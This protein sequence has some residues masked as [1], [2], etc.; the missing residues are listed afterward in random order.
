M[1]FYSSFLCEVFYFWA[2]APTTGIS[3]CLSRVEINRNH[4]TL[5][6][7]KNRVQYAGETVCPDCICGYT[8]GFDSTT[9]ATIK[10]AVMWFYFS[11]LWEG[12]LFL[13]YQ[14]IR[15]GSFS[16]ENL[17]GNAN[18]GCADEQIF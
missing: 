1:R 3:A 8:R 4:A 16:L 17:V 11:F 10:E 7:N 6:C 14:C 18:T 2:K 5:V 9:F 12:F 13:G 15:F